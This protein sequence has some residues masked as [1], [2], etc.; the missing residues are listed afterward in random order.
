MIISNKYA[1][2]KNLI[3]IYILNILGEHTF[4]AQKYI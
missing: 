1:I 3:Y 2:K 4:C